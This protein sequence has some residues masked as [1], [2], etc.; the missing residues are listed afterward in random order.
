MATKS[1]TISFKDYFSEEYDFLAQ[2][3]NKSLFICELIREYMNGGNI[4][5][6]KSSDVSKITSP[7]SQEIEETIEEIEELEVKKERVKKNIKG[8]V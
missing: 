4:Q 1:V 2:Q 3:H 5:N 8:I 6:V 7:S